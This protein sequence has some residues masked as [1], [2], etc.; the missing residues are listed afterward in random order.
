MSVLNCVG[1]GVSF[2]SYANVRAN[3][4]E[5]PG[6]EAVVERSYFKID[7]LCKILQPSQD[8]TCVGVSF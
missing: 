2:F 8:N 5:Q 1:S 4:K 3:F 6:L 7:I